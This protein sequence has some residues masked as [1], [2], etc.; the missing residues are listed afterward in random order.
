MRGKVYRVGNG[1]GCQESKSVS[2]YTSDTS[3]NGQGL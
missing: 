2:R 1:E 3:I